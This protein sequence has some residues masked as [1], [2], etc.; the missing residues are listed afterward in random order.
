MSRRPAIT[1]LLNGQAAKIGLRL[2][3]GH[4]EPRVLA[5]EEARRGRAREAAADDHDARLRILRQHGA[6]QQ[7]RGSARPRP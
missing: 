4:G 7:R 1:S 2:H 5:L 6:G 3:E